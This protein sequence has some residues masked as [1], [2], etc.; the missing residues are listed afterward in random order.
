MVRLTP[1][2]VPI[3]EGEFGHRG[4]EVIFDSFTGLVMDALANLMGQRKYIA[5][6][7]LIYAQAELFSFLGDYR[8]NAKV[9]KKMVRLV[10][11]DVDEFIFNMQDSFSEALLSFGANSVSMDEHDDYEDSDEVH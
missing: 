4:Q 11:Q 5:L 6:E 2:I 3:L 9:D 10:F 1:E 8:T 7:V